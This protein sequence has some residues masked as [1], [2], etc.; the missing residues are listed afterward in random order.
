MLHDRPVSIKSFFSLF[1]WWCLFFFTALPGWAASGIGDPH[2]LLSTDQQVLGNGETHLH[3]FDVPQA[4]FVDVAVVAIENVDKIGISLTTEAGIPTGGS[5]TT[6]GNVITLSRR[7]IPANKTGGYSASVRD[8]IEW[9]YNTDAI[10]TLTVTYTPLLQD[11]F[12]SEPTDNNVSGASQVNVNQSVD[13]YLVNFE[14]YFYDGYAYDLDWY[15]IDVNEPG[16]LDVSLTGVSPG[17]GGANVNVRLFLTDL[18]GNIVGW[19]SE[20]IGQTSTVQRRYIAG[21]KLGTYRIQIY[22]D[23]IM[24]EWHWSANSYNFIVNHTPLPTGAYDN[25]PANDESGGALPITI[26]EVTTGCLI[27]YENYF[28]DGFAGDMDWYSFEINQPGQLDVA[29]TGVGVGV[30]TQLALYDPQG[31]LLGFDTATSTDLVTIPTQDITSDMIGTFQINVRDDQNS[32]WQWSDSPYTVTVTF[33]PQQYS[34][35]VGISGSGNVS[36]DGIVCPDY[37]SKNYD[38]ITVVTLTA[39]PN[40]GWVFDS[41][42]GDLTGSTSPDTVTIDANMNVTATF[43]EDSDGDGVP[44]VSDGCPVDSNKIAAGFCGCGTPE[45]DTDNDGSP[46]CVDECP[47]DPDKTSP[48]MCGC[49]VS[50]TDSD[51]DGTLDCND[52]CPLDPN[53][54]AEGICGCG[55]PDA[56]ADGDGTMDCND[57]CPDDA[58]K[59]EPGVCGCGVGDMDSDGDGTPDCVDNCPGDPNKVD[60]GL[61]GCGVAETDSDGDGTPDCID[62]CPDDPNKTEPGQCG[63]GK[64]DTDTDGDGAPDCIDNCPETPN[65]DQSDIDKDGIGDVCDALPGDVDDSDLI[66]LKDAIL[67]IQ[68]IAGTNLSNNVHKAADVNGDGKIGLEETIY[69][70]RVINQESVYDNDGDGYTEDQGDCDDMNVDIN[71]GA[72]DICE[73]GI[74]QDCTN[75]DKICPQDNSGFY[76]IYNVTMV[77]GTCP[78]EAI[79]ITIGSDIN[80]LQEAG[81]VYIPSSGNYHKVSYS[82]AGCQATRAIMISDNVIRDIQEGNSGINCTEYS[83]R[84]E[85]VSTFSFNDGTFTLAGSVLEE[86]PQGSSYS[87][88]G[89]VSGSGTMAEDGEGTY[90]N[91]LG[92]TFKLISAGTFTMGS[93]TDPIEPGRLSEETQHQVTITQPFYMQ[94]R[95]VTQGQWQAVMGSNPSHFQNCGDDCPVEYVSWLDVQMFISQLN[96]RGEGAYRLPTEAEWE[97]AARAGSGTAFANGDISEHQQYCDNTNLDMMGWYCGNANSTTHPVA[98]KEPN[99]W[100]LYD[101]HG[102]VW[103]WCQDWYGDYSSGSVTDPT[104]P[105][106][107]N[108]RVLRGGSWNR[109]ARDCRSAYRLSYSPVFVSYF[110]GFRLLRIP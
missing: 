26:G 110:L 81:Y 79:Q 50:D 20:D 89:S 21:N 85:I 75:G 24:G 108:S 60:P 98:Q 65:S 64:V 58:D 40:P 78:A 92:M 44:D 23:L 42:S 41:W 47:N 63:C 104:G 88:Q 49:G 35:T 74:D 10:Y 66:D 56:D 28:Y 102:N 25:E 3:P 12:A 2:V 34:L 84:N 76:G 93:P 82:E 103:E 53:K 4:G 95:E 8:I 48:G 14:N 9:Y 13:N 90:T 77:I 52:N 109:Y 99:D 80:R 7:F 22:Q 51:N 54:I 62:A 15:T 105:S 30:N 33:V 38:N 5:A 55:K 94:A 37:C 73:D 29:W 107:G 19:T 91:S 70:L 16:Y 96:N 86:N 71:P 43:L 61:C 36:G 67:A 101:M 106:G 100:G 97:Y 31:N 59:T 72:F 11:V 6:D 1:T 45:T 32:E 18:S 46:D 39:S 83:W 17:Y 27:A 69:I 57:N 68:V 87:C